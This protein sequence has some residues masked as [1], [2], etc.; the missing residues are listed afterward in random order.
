MGSILG[1]RVVRVEDPRLLT[2]GGTYVEDLDAARR[3]VAHLR[4]LA[5]RPTPA[6]PRIDIGRG[7]GAARRARRAHR[8]RP[9][10]ARARR[11]TS[12]PAFP[13]AHAPAVRGRRHRALRRPAG[14]GGHR[15]GPG[16]RVPTP[17]T[18]SSSTTTRCPPSSSPRR[19]PRDEVLL[20]PEAGTNVVQRFASKTPADFADC[21][22]V[23]GRAHR[24]PAHDGGARS[25]PARAPRYWTDD[26]RLVHYS[27]CQGAHPTRDLLADD[28]RP[29]AGAGA[30]GRARRGR[31]LRRQVPHLSRRSWPSAFY[32]RRGRPA[33]AVDRDPLGEHGGHAPRPGPGAAR[34][35]R[36]HARRPHHRLPA[37]RG[38]GRRRLPADRC[39]AAEHDACA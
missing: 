36:R 1:N 15:R 13:E 2:A 35:P 7:R 3:G 37:R 34:P 29:R 25:R 18:S 26:G 16:H 6:S 11:P 32:A 22:V 27:A 24:Q 17:P 20:F 5:V 31:R 8:R 28:L 4:P 12:T 10:R 9:R 39:G 21:E 38:A 14:G 19:R 23:V 33:G 30:G